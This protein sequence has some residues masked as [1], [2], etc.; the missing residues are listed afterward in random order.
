MSPLPFDPEGFEVVNVLHNADNALILDST[1]VP[2]LALL[3]GATYPGA[4]KLWGSTNK[5]E[6]VGSIDQA[7]TLFVDQSRDGGAT[8]PAALTEQWLGAIGEAFA[9]STARALGANAY[10]LRFTAGGVNLA[11]LVLAPYLTVGLADHETPL[12]RIPV[13]VLPIPGID[14]H[15]VIPV[16][17]REV[18]LMT[19]GNGLYAPVVNALVFFSNGPALTITGPALGDYGR[20]GAFNIKTLIPETLSDAATRPVDLAVINEDPAAGKAWVVWY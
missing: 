13:T 4:A 14:I 8:W 9:F 6:I 7:G 12:K 16:G 15:F 20:M 3:A 18:Q 1:N 19:I 5:L 17:A 10:R 2:P 11:A